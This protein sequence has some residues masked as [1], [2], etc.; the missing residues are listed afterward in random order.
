MFSG[1]VESQARV[2]HFNSRDESVYRLII[3]R[4]KEIGELRLGESIALNGVCLTL[5]DQTKSE[6][7]FDV[8][9]ETLRVT[10]WGPDLVGCSLNLEKS[11]QW[12]DRVHGHLVTGHVDV[13]ASVLRIRE[14][15]LWREL[16]IDLPHN[17]SPLVWKK[18]SISVNGVSLTVNQV[19]SESFTVCLIPETLKRT[20]LGLVQP[21]DLVLLE[22]DNMARG[23]QRLREVEL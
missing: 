14:G 2:L 7:A 18:G 23:L 13:T 21:G 17:L 1:I 20:N 12:G 9:P 22:A 4:P 3:Q 6:L 19:D 10:G 15:T 8:G 16:T 5:S 11:L